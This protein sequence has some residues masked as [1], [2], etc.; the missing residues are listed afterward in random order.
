MYKLVFANSFFKEYKILVKKNFKLK[1]RIVKTFEKLSVNPKQSSLKSHK[2]STKKFGERWSSTVTKDIRII[3]DYD[4]K[5]QL[6]I[7][8]LSLGGHTGKRK[9]Y[10]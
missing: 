6:T 8:V 1:K 2:V 7:L 9:V 5:L 10:N 4:N 3:W